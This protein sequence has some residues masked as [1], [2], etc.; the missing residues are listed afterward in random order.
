M[1]RRSPSPPANRKLR[2][3]SRREGISSTRRLA[4]GSAILVIASGMAGIWWW[5]RPERLRAHAVAA[6]KTG[7]WA[8]ALV[9]WRRVNATRLARGATFLAEARAALALGRAAEAEKL[10]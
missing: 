8:E 10:T 3:Q 2:H 6:A 4:L 9:S 1:A 7:N 5:T